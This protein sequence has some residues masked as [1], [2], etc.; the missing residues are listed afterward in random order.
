M[1]KIISIKQI[2][3]SKILKKDKATYVISA[4]ILVLL[5][6][7][8]I[9]INIKSSKHG[10]IKINGILMPDFLKKEQIGVYIDGEVNKPRLYKTKKRSNIK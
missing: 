10:G 7:F 6:I 1:I 9:G 5:I 3:I 8:F 2:I 4:L